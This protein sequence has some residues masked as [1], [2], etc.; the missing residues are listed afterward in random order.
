MAIMRRGATYPTPTVTRTGPT[1][2]VLTDQLT[3]TVN[4]NV[5]YESGLTFGGPTAYNPPGGGL[6]GYP[7]APSSAYDAVAAGGYA[8]CKALGFSESDCQ[9][10]K[11]IV[12]GLTGGGGGGNGGG[13]NGTSVLP[14]SDQVP[15][16]KGCK[17]GFVLGPDGV[18]YAQ[19]SP[20]YGDVV[21]GGGAQMGVFGAP[22]VQPRAVGQIS[23]DRGEVKPILRCPGGTVLGKDNLCYAK[24]SIP[25]KLRKWPKAPRPPITRRDA[26]AIR[27]AESARN[28]VKKLAG[29]VGFT[30]KKR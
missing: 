24:G 9:L 27:R 23:N 6:P 4:R 5:Q 17:A 25:N 16:G 14:Y 7:S 29:D 18:C 10:A 30:C 1:S 19:G 21:G 26:V 15:A 13:G 20:G 2:V 3:P 28:R 8:L 11:S 22:A 12:S